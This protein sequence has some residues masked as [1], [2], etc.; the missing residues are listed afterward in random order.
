MGVVGIVMIDF[1]NVSGRPEAAKECINDFIPCL[2]RI[3]SGGN[4]LH[5]LKPCIDEEIHNRALTLQ[6]VYDDPGRLEINKIRRKNG[7]TT[8]ILLGTKGFNQETRIAGEWRKIK[9]SVDAE[10]FLNNRM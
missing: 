6:E 4:G 8:N 1:D 9:N 3:S 7:F 2:V 5:I 10:R